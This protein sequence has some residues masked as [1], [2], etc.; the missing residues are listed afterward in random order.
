[1]E[2]VMDN[3]DVVDRL[4]RIETKL[5]TLMEDRDRLTAVEKKQWFHTGGIAALVVVLNKIGI[6]LTWH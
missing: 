4:A 3:D 2:A 5:D 1:V 6:P